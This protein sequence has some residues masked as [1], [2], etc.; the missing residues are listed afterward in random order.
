VLAAVDI[1]DTTAVVEGRAFL[2]ELVADQIG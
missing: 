1:S 2:E